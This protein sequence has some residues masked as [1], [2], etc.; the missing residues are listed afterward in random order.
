MV[1][2]RP[3]FDQVNVLASQACWAWPQA[4]RDIFRPRG[5]NLLVARDAGEFV[6]V[7]GQKRIH[8]AIIDM[9]VEKTNA[10]AI[11]KIIRMRYPLLP[12]ILLAE[13]IGANLL[14]KALKLDVFSVIDKPV[15]MSILLEQLNRLFIKKYDSNIFERSSTK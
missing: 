9:D 1:A 11:V 15:D 6:N 13:R 2:L 8:T 4:L 5:V 14:G 3:Q 10:L 12:C 7:I